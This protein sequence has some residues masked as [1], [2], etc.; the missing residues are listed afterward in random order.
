MQR[1]KV[2]SSYSSWKDIDTGVPQGSIL[3]PV[4]YNI[5]S[6]DL[7]LFILLDIVNFADDNSPFTV[8]PSTSIVLSQLEHE[9]KILLEWIKN[10]GLKANPDKFHLL[11]SEPD[12]SLSIKVGDFDINN[13]KS[14]KLLGVTFDNKLSFKE[15]VSSL[16]RK[17]SQKIHALS[18]V[19]KYTKSKESN[20]ENVCSISFWLLPFSM[21]VLWSNSK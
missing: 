7:F 14:Q 12:E 8:A 4:L 6:N 9:S 3:G 13:S 16:C 1:V 17:A 10:N 21:D 15:H 19:C 18:R 5:N 2:N 20:Y 11:L